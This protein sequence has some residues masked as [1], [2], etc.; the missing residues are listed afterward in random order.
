MDIVS[1]VILGLIQGI[2]EFLPISSSAHLALGHNMFGL[3]SP[4]AGSNVTFDVLLHLGTLIAVFI[5]F[6]RDIIGLIRAFFSL[7]KKIFTGK[8][9]F[10]TL[11]ADEK[12]VIYILIATLPLLAAVFFSDYV[13]VLSGY[14]KIIG[15]ILIVNGIVLLLSDR[16]GSG[17]RGIEETKPMNALVVGL[18]QMCA[19]VPG[20]SRSGA[21]ITGGLFQGFRRDFAVKFSFIL[22]I[23]AILGANIL[24]IKDVAET[25]ATAGE[26]GVYALGAAVA[27]LSGIAAMKFLLYISKK[28]NF[29][30]FAY[31]C[32]AVGLLAII[33]G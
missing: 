3:T 25:G 12:F 32:F 1:A 17:D 14:S 7:C 20:L 33:F 22:S 23:P 19:V 2:A 30:Y 5:V 9:K 16:L 29:T 4:D 6:R 10:R 18:C 28:A 21:T 26:W 8:C 31:Y 27:A 24:K 13:E 11:E 15:G